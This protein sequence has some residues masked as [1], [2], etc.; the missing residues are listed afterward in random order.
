MES[1]QT[2]FGEGLEVSVLRML[3]LFDRPV[4]EK[5]L[6]ALMKP[7][8]YSGPNRVFDGFEPDRVAHK[9]CQ[10]KESEAPHSRRY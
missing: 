2:W 6:C 3:G 5:V 9:S 10:I 7:P 8:C 4:D 1:Y